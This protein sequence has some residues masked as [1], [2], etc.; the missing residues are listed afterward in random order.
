MLDIAQNYDRAVIVQRLTG[1]EDTEK[2]T[3]TTHINGVSC[4]I[5]P[6]DE[7]YSEDVQ[8]NF[9]KDWLMFCPVADILEDDKVVDGEKEYKVVGVESFNFLGMDRHMEVRL[10]RFYP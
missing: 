5:Q 9:G 8:G 2:E 7:S 3:Y 6:L 10:R 4:H 1:V